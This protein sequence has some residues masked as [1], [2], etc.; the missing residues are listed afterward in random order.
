MCL[1]DD[2][3]RGMEYE[4]NSFYDILRKVVNIFEFWRVCGYWEL[5]ECFG[6][7]D[8]KKLIGDVLELIEN[9]VC[10]NVDSWEKKF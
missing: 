4:I 7:K 8:I 1:V 2:F 5:C 3:W 6:F 10:M 9:C